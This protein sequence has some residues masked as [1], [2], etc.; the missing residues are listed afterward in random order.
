M[1]LVRSGGLL[2]VELVNGLS[3]MP[4]FKRMG[5][6]VGNLVAL[7]APPHATPGSLHGFLGT[8]AMDML[9]E[10]TSSLLLWPR[11]MSL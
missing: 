10:Q 8:F 1:D 7:L 6:L 5:V 2:G 3:L 4:K 11:S 9:A